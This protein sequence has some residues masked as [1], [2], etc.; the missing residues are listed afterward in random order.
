MYLLLISFYCR[1]GR[2]THSKQ[3][4]LSISS[5]HFIFVWRV[6][7][8]GYKVDAKTDVWFDVG[9]VGSLFGGSGGFVIW[10]LGGGRRM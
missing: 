8:R 3:Y 7:G 10:I 2:F 1:Y 9:W 5:F 6:R 4:T